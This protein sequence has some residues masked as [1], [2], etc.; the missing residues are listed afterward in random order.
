M[1]KK[2]EYDKKE[3]D[4][5]RT[6]PGSWYL[7]S[8]KFRF[9]LSHFQPWFD[10]LKKKKLVG[11]QCRSCNRVFFP[12]KLV[13]G[14]CFI[15]PDLWVDVRETAQVATFSITYEKNPQTGEVTEKPIVCIRHDGT[16]TSFLGQ[17]SS[18]I[19]FKDS[20]VGMPVKLKW[21]D[22]THGNISDLEC[23]EPIE[24]NAKE[25]RKKEKK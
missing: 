8:Y 11:L 17:L 20:Y 19:N 24:D 12:P 3:Y 22:E 1:S 21:A 23:Y 25:L 15:K 6:M 14:D 7:S 5:T 2:L 9:D 13:C 16:D 4:T 10:N 18:E